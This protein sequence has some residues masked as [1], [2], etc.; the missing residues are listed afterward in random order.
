MIGAIARISLRYLSGALITYGLVSPDVG[1]QIAV[2]PDLIALAGIA[3]G[4]AV[5]GV[6]ALAVRRGWAT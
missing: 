4:A 1:A 3:I 6:Y 2:D 5:E